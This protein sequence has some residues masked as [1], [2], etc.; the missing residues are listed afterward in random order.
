[1]QSR[2]YD[3]SSPRIVQVSAVRYSRTI[4]GLLASTFYY[5]V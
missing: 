4:L 1:M 3:K 2:G 5:A